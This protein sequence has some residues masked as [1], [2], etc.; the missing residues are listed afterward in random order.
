MVKV[1]FRNIDILVVGAGP[2]GLLSALWFA[3]QGYRIVCIEQYGRRPKPEVG[4]NKHFKERH[5]QIG[6]NEESLNLLR[7]I[8]MQIW[9]SLKLK[10]CVDGS[11]MNIPIYLLQGILVSR[12]KRYRNVKILFET[13][14]NRVNTV[15]SNSNCQILLGSATNQKDNN[16]LSESQ[17]S[18]SS[19]PS[20]I[21]DVRPRLVIV[22]DGKSN[23]GV[24][25]TFFG[26]SCAYTI[27]ESTYGLVGMIRRPIPC[28]AI[29]LKNYSSNEYV[30]QSHPE[31]GPLYFRL[32]GSYQER[33][34]ALGLVNPQ[35]RNDFLNLPEGTIVNLLLEAHNKHKTPLEPEITR[36]T[37]YSREPITMVLGYR[38]QTLKILQNSTTI[39]T[40]QGDAAR[41]TSFFSGSALNTGYKSLKELFEFCHKNEALIFRSTAPFQ[42]Q[43]RVAQENNQCRHIS[44]ELVSEGLPYFKQQNFFSNYAPRSTPYHMRTYSDIFCNPLIG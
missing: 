24:S 14:I 4:K 43:K 17:W 16:S 22:A 26:F 10:G 21:Y 13:K 9:E 18:K 5:Q 27:N 29:C 11:W 32:L 28:P 37:E 23:G 19:T 30:S 38:P 6:L 8:D 36:L 31:Y 2:V 41:K 44:T 7:S 3:K 15:D 40:V 1:K 33:Y 42:L 39:V 34:I 20:K 12:L 35:R 25:E